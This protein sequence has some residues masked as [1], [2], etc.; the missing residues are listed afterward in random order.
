ML[1]LMLMLKLMGKLTLKLMGKLKLRGRGG[2]SSRSTRC[3][4]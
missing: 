1:M 2:G 3:M 4:R